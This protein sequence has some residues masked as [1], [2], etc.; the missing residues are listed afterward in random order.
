M[1]D[2]RNLSEVER[3]GRPTIA[4]SF[5]T[6]RNSL[7]FLRLLLALAVI[8]SHSLVLGSFGSESILGKATLGTMAVYGF[9]GISGY[10]I[11]GSAAR[12][13]VGRYLWQRFL[14]IFPAFWACLLVTAFIFGT[15]G[16]FH[17]NPH[18]SSVCGLHC[19]LSEPYGPVGYVIHNF[20]LQINQ[21]SITNTMPATFQNQ[22]WDGSLWTLQLEFLCYLLLAALS[23]LG[24]LRRRAL[25]ALLA[26]IAWIAE[27]VIVSVPTWAVDFTPGH[28]LE[29]LGIGVL[30][31]RVEAISL[32]G[33]V[34]IFLAGSLLYL[35]R[36][37]IPDSGAI[38]LGATVLVLAG[39]IIPVGQTD[40][41][42]NTTSFDLTAVFLAYP[43]IW[44]GIHLPFSRVCAV[45]DYSY[46]IYIYA[47]PVQQLLT[48]WG[49][50]KW[51]YLAY[52]FLAILAVIPLAVAS[53]WLI[54]KHA[55]KL[56]RLKLPGD[57]RTIGV[58]PP[59]T[60]VQVQVEIGSTADAKWVAEV[61][62]PPF[63]RPLSE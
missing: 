46:G 34:S 59:P 20:W 5:S 29:L 35:Y 36:E 39:L 10:L 50:N 3:Q 62:E 14:R 43:L 15:I 13:N 24:L 55:L 44:L 18:L 41:L 57:F 48:M 1:T 58:T 56:K 11:A 7:N 23:V 49:V 22:S 2:A 51:G 26:A 61:P 4:D 16:W 27:I 40:Y 31:F 19:Y 30:G 17:E 37:K 53:W 32:L 60:S 21:G 38:A 28:R 52:T 25:V 8:F 63:N 6:R 42:Y 45:N 9:F 54:E 12:N 47:F 33:L